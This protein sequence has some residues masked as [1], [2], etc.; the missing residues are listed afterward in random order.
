M[1]NIANEAANRSKL[2]PSVKEKK[3]RK[4]TKSEPKHQ[5]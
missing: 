5:S 2:K 1:S 3:I 4:S